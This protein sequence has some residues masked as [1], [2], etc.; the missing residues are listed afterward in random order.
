[1]VR[2]LGEG[3]SHIPGFPKVQLRELTLQP[4]AVFAMRTMSNSMVCHMKEGEL[5]IDQEVEKFTAKKGTI[6]TCVEGG[7][8][9]ATNAGSTV[10]IMSVSDLLKT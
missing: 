9:A 3:K 4:G 1:M 10:A 5:L 6:W 7:K 8:E 2:T